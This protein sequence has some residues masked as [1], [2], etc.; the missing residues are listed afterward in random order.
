MARRFQGADGI[1]ASACLIVLV[2]HSVVLLYQGLDGYLIGL[3]KIGVWIF[4]V[5]SAFLLTC[6]F[7]SDGFTPKVLGAYTV[8]RVLRILPLYILF[9]CLY[10]YAGTAGIDTDS[11]LWQAMSLQ[12]GYSHLWTI[13]VEFKYYLFLPFVAFFAIWCRKRMGD[14]A[15]IIAGLMLVIL[16]QLVWPYWHTPVGTADVRWYF[17]CFTIGT[18][19]AVLFPVLERSVSGKRADM[20]VTILMVSIIFISPYVQF[21]L[22]GVEPNDYLVNKFVFLSFGCALLTVFLINGAGFYGRLFMTRPFVM[23]GRWSYSIYL[24]HWLVIVKISEFLSF[25]LLGVLI[26]IGLSILAGA[27]IHYAIEQP[28]E[29]FR[30]KVMRKLT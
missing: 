23:I 10:R 21:K 20:L 16:Q 13:P 11:D 27:I 17:S 2:L 8:G 7:E 26:S 30:H 15:A 14:T 28:L 4:F 1:R 18:F 24:V 29:K 25:S 3:P 12:T 5:L 9:V 19:A 6:K 22:F